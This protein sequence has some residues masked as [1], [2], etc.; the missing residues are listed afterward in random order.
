MEYPDVESIVDRARLC[1]LLRDLLESSQT[2]YTPDDLQSL[3]QL[4][5]E[6]IQLHLLYTARRT[7]D[8]FKA[9][10]SSATN[11]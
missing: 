11:S 10:R 2:C 9:R 3:V 6:E 4:V 7:V 1:A 8:W 5:H